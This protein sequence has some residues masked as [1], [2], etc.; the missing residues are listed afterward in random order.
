MVE[1]ARAS[2]TAVV[3]GGGRE[4]RAAVREA[5]VADGV[6]IVKDGASNVFVH[7]A[8]A[9][10][11]SVAGSSPDDVAQGLGASLTAA[12]LNL[13]SGVAAIRS[14]GGGGAVV[15]VAPASNARAFGPLRQGLRLLAKSA[16]LELGPEGIRVNIILPGEGE[17]PLGRACSPADIAAAVAF[18]AGDRSHF[19]TGAD[20]VID[21]G[22]MA[23]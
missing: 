1:T 16:A 5:F 15:F 9:D 20:I 13:Q 23:L 14:R 19:M 12:F 8:D 7:V 18:A 3:H 22:R 17:A 10:A 2:R 11:T 4:L 6:E 21:G